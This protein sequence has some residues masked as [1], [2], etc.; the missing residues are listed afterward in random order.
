MRL[1]ASGLWPYIDL[2]GVELNQPHKAVCVLWPVVRAQRDDVGVA[3]VQARRLGLAMATHAA[4]APAHACRH[5]QGKKQGAGGSAVSCHWAFRRG[6]H[7]FSIRQAPLQGALKVAVLQ[8]QALTRV[9]THA[10]THAAAAH[11]DVHAALAT[12]ATAHAAAATATEEGRKE[13]HRVHLHAGMNAQLVLLLSPP[14]L[15]HR[16]QHHQDAV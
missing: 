11:V 9:A 1:S 14:P 10:A 5:G 4:A 16:F 6:K 8:W 7:C 13:I 15:A 3:I 2:R 12:H